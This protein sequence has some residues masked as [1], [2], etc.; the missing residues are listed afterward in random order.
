MIIWRLNMYS[1]GSNVSPNQSAPPPAYGS[2][3]GGI[4]RIWHS[5][6]LVLA[7]VFSAVSGG[8]VGT[9]A[10]FRW[11]LPEPSTASVVSAEPVAAQSN[12]SVAIAS[13]VFEQVKDAVV[14]VNVSG[15]APGGVM[16]LG[17]GTGFVVD[18]RGLVLTNNHVVE[19]GRTVSVRFNNG[20]E[21]EAQVL[22]TDRGNDL[23]L[24]RVD[25]PVNTP[26]IHLADSDQVQVGETVIAIGSPFGL[27]QTVTQG[28]VSAT[29]RDWWPGSGRVQ[30]DLIQTDAPIN[31]GNSGGPLLNA[32]GEV[33]GINSMIESPV[34][35]SVG[36]G[37]AIPINT[38]KELLPRL[39]AGAQLE[40][41]WLG[42]AG[43]DLNPAIVED[44]NLSVEEGV[45]VISVVPNGPADQAG[46]Q[47]G[48]GLN[49]RV[50]RGGDV[51][52]AVDGNA[53]KNM[54]E[55][56]A[57]V[58]GHA[59][60]DVITLTIVRDGQERQVDVTLQGWPEANS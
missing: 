52:T 3:R 60:G 44:Q 22:G 13:K 21:R 35:G 47:G 9:A 16:S 46:I 36:I 24:L 31:P 49:E 51:I 19:N 25:L 5:T 29:G 40:P 18:A 59:P 10:A 15:E 4:R 20:Q 28:I 23:A 42:I 17:S 14:H 57:H 56:A 6:L 45:L 12:S 39:E 48:E 53:V 55:L 1:D 7:L 54:E 27:E 32:R 26:V 30:R 50:P 33:I 11:V 38:A 58:A 37:F 41:A 8:A 34:R 2:Q 43:H